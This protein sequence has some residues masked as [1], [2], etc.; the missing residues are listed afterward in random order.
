MS[1]EVEK[2]ME[3]ITIKGI[4]HDTEAPIS[5]VANRF[6]AEK[7]MMEG[8]RYRASD[9]DLLMI[10]DNEGIGKARKIGNNVVEGIPVAQIIT[11]KKNTYKHKNGDVLDNTFDNF[12]PRKKAKIVTW[13]K[14]K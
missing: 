1:K 3:A 11:G 10:K 4:D 6:H 7:H 9:G 14:V 2:M 12:T 13:C 8:A 5:I